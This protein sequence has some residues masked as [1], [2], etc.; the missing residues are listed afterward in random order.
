MRFLLN[1][2]RFFVCMRLSCLLSLYSNVI[3]LTLLLFFLAFFIGHAVYVMIFVRPKK[4]IIYIFNDLLTKYLKR[5]RLFNALPVILFMPLFISAFTAFKTLIPIMNPY[6]WDQTF[7]EIDK[8][9]HGGYQAWQ[10]LQ[11]ILGHPLLTSI[12]NFFLQ[13]LVF[14]YVCCIILAGL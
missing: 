7:A 2:Q 12:I 11:P 13:S 6:S 10:L 14:C 8:M 1:W 5:K 3:P 9:I 4:L